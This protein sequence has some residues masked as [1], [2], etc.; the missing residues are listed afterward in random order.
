MRK[1]ILLSLLVLTCSCCSSLR[2]KVSTADPKRVKEFTDA[3]DPFEKLAFDYRKILLPLLQTKII[4]EKKQ[5][6]D[7]S[8]K[9][10][11]EIVDSGEIAAIDAND[12]KSNFRTIYTSQVDEIIASY[13]VA[14]TFMIDKQYHQAVD[15]YLVLLQKF[16]T[17]AS[18]LNIALTSISLTSKVN[19]IEPVKKEAIISEITTGVAIANSAF[20]N[21]RANLLGDKL[22]GYI[23]MK[24]NK[25]IWKSTYNR[26]ASRTYFGN[27]DIAVVLN[28]MPNNYNNNYSIK[29]V[30]VDAAKLIQSTFDV[31][32]QVVN[33]AASMSGITLPNTS[34]DANSFHPQEFTQI[35]EL[36]QKK[37]ELQNRKEQL[38]QSQRQLLLKILG[39][40]MQ[41][42]EIAEIQVSVT[43]IKQ[44]WDTYKLNLANTT[45]NT[46]GP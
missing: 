17:L 7:Q 10:I 14:N 15:I 41:H 1:L 2:V 25:G 6:T 38:K 8:D 34:G 46:T 31:M 26:T 13:N 21:G 36:P 44:F 27:A 16:N 45:T 33:V 19:I 24:D 20:Y 39:E 30:R 28:E 11:K 43:D 4:T 12:F 32:T 29:G 3:I 35:K 40:N 23:T 22:V 9:K 18:N 5:I 42:K 37:A